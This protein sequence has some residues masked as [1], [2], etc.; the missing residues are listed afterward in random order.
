MGEGE[1]G[2]ALGIKFWEVGHLDW[3]ANHLPLLL[4]GVN[5]IW[6]YGV[7]W[8][9]MEG[10]ATGRIVGWQSVSLGEHR[11]PGCGGSL[12]GRWVT[13]QLVDW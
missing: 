3:E 4:A 5:C 6:A 12:P 10:Q 11:N 1:G 13:H 9:C 8:G 7:C 2:C